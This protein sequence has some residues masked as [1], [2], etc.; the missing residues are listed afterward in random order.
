MLKHLAVTGI[1]ALATLGMTTPLTAQ[2]RSAVSATDLETAVITA[3]APNQAEVQRF[4]HDPR[5]V[6]AA[7]GLGVRA[8]DLSAGVSR[9]DE[10]TLRQV[11]QQIRAGDPARAGGSETVVITS[12]LLILI[13][14]VVIILLVA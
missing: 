5:V 3:P 1:L 13:L 10:G 6:E 2:A 11:A 8:A 4:L 9:L 12:T 14:L 7:N